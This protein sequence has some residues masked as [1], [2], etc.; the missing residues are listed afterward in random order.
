MI[1]II[2]IKR[3]D[4]YI[5]LMTIER[6]I[7]IMPDHRLVFDLPFNIPAGKANVKITISPLEKQTTSDAESVFGCLHRFSKPE[8]INGEK[9][10]WMHTAL[11]KQ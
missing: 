1:L 6:T 8:K 4:C 9:S 2:D 3:M 5:L 11:K 10:A 7:D